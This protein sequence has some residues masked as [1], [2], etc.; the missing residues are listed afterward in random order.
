LSD[1]IEKRD[2]ASATTNDLIECF[3]EYANKYGDMHVNAWIQNACD[4]PSMRFSNALLSVLR[5]KARGVKA[6]NPSDAFSKLTTP[7]Q[8]S[9]MQKEHESLLRILAGISQEKKT[10]DLFSKLEARHV[11]EKIAGTELGRLLEKHAEEYGWL[12]YGYVG[13]GWKKDYFTE[14]LCSL[15][16]QGADGARMLDENEARKKR[17]K[18]DQR[19]IIEELGLDDKTISL[20]EVA[21]GFIY[22]KGFRK[23]CMFKFFSK[24]EPF[25]TE[26]AKRRQVSINDL[27]FCYPGEIR[28][29]FKGELPAETLKERRNFSLRE[30]RVPHD[31]LLEGDR[32]G[33]HLA[34]LSFVQEKQGE[35]SV[36]NGT[37]ASPGRGRGRA[38]IVNVVKDVE[39]MNKGDVL[40]SIATMPDL[41]PAMKKASAIVTDMG[42]ITCHA[43]IVSR[44][45]NIPCVVGT[46]NATKTIKDGYLLDVDATHGAVKIIET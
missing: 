45:L 44:E 14:L 36:L 7:L 2:Y 40:V 9:F 41:V 10:V 16:R 26:V 27:R 13:P 5:D 8:D 3:D 35:V 21:K 34:A 19:K 37:C 33:R 4:M 29:L 30:S 38:K 23:D 39:K 31:L 17:L 1:E 46:R 42:G 28:A 18:E 43:A 12:G 15:V 32:A 24:I 25:W 6:I 11:A 20:F 22:A